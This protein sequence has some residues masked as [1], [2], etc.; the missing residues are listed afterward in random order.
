MLLTHP[1]PPLSPSSL[2]EEPEPPHAPSLDELLSAYTLQATPPAQVQSVGTRFDGTVNVVDASPAPSLPVIHER[3]SGPFAG[4]T[5]NPAF[6]PPPLATLDV[7]PGGAPV[8]ALS[9]QS[10]G[11]PAVSHGH[12][13]APSALAVDVFA[14]RPDARETCGP[15]KQ[16]NGQFQHR[17]F[18]A[19]DAF[20]VGVVGSS[21]VGTPKTVSGDSSP[22]VKKLAY[23]VFPGTRAAPAAT[24]AVHEESLVRA[25]V[26]PLP[27]LGPPPVTRYG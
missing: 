9:T 12:S 5:F 16:S 20:P 4:G 7:F 27:E 11:L 8:G 3:A 23:E 22:I 17:N 21:V 14:D 10:L 19:V 1:L 2:F 24:Y 6:A 15:V 26:Q 18:N 13:Y 25:N